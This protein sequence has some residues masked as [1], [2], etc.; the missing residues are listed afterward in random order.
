M[1]KLISIVKGWRCKRIVPDICTRTY[2]IHVYALPGVLKTSG[3]WR[4]FVSISLSNKVKF[5]RHF[6]WKVRFGTYISSMFGKINILQNDRY[7]HTG[8]I[9]YMYNIMRWLRCFRHIW[10]VEH[11][12]NKIGSS[13]HSVCAAPITYTHTW[14]VEF[15][16]SS[17]NTREDR[18]IFLYAQR[19][20]VRREAFIRC[21]KGQDRVGTKR[22]AFNMNDSQMAQAQ[23]QVRKSCYIAFLEKNNWPQQAA[24]VLSSLHHWQGIF[25]TRKLCEDTKISAVFCGKCFGFIVELWLSRFDFEHCDSN[26]SIMCFM[27]LFIFVSISFI[28]SF[29]EIFLSV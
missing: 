1:I 13:E 16:L 14:C 24:S 11:A 2:Y 15:C 12:D 18:V 5:G 10:S 9:M 6:T 23:A 7:L 22:P 21:I 17:G 8:C 26:L 29:Y 3:C 27:S 19:L 25:E 28:E 20:S 4:T